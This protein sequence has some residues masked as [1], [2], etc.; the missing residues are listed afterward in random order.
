[1]KPEGKDVLISGTARVVTADN[2][3]Q[4]MHP[5]PQIQLMGDFLVARDVE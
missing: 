2:G 4:Q 1:M 3:N 5:E